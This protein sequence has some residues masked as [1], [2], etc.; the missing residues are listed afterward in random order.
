LRRSPPWP[1]VST[2]DPYTDLWRVQVGEVET[3]AGFAHDTREPAL[4]AR[5]VAALVGECTENVR[6]TNVDD[7]V[8]IVEVG[9][10]PSGSACRPER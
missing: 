6:K 4:S 1:T 9:M 7:L 5:P 8:R 2:D 3:S 10:L